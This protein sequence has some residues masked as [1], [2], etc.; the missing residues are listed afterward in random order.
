MAS[1]LP[2]RQ[3]AR[4]LIASLA[5]F[6]ASWG[7]G[8]AGL[9]LGG[10]GVLALVVP[11]GLIFGFR[12]YLTL[13]AVWELETGESAWRLMFVPAFSPRRIRARTRVMLDLLRPQWIRHT[14]RES[15]WNP[16]LAGYGLLTLLVA[17]LIIAALVFPHLPS[18]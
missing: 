16:K 7:I 5:L 10:P 15:G 9:G 2:D 4:S 8:V 11:V 14:L 13:Y 6:W 17:D 12:F 3:Q 1:P 18:N